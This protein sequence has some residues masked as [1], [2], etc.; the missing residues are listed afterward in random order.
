MQAIQ[1]HPQ[2]NVA[3]AMGDLP[4]GALI[5]VAGATVECKAPIPAMHKLALKS[6]GMGGEVR[7]YGQVIGFASTEIRPGE[8]VHV[9]NCRVGDVEMD[10]GFCRDAVTPDFVPE[11]QRDTFQGY[12]RPG[13][14]AG[15]RNYVGVLTSVN[16]SATVARGIAAVGEALLASGDYPGIDGVVA[17]GHSSGCG[18]Q[19]D[20]EGYLTLR[21]TIVGYARHPNFAAVMLVGLGCET[22][23]ISR[24]M[25]E[26]GLADTGRFRAFTIQESG[27]TRAAI[28]R[29]AAVLREMLPL[30]AACRR[31]PVPVSELAMAVQCGGSDAFSGITANP[32]LGAAGDILVRQGGTVIYSETPEICGAEHLL[33]RRAATPEVAEAL[34]ERIRWWEQY[35]RINGIQLDSNP[36]PGNKAGGLTTILEKSLGAQAKSGSSPMTGVYRYAEPIARHGLAFMDSPGYDPVSVTGQVASGANIICFTTGRGSAFGFK[37]VPSLKLASNSALFQRMRDDMDVDCG[38]VLEGAR[39][40]QDMGR[41]IYQRVLAIAS[42]ERSKSEE[43]GYGDCEFNPW[44]IGATV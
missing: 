2:D 3:V 14:A 33:T 43:L 35:T 9:Q 30:A 6:I 38:P 15:T 21:R 8:H 27:G 11:Q 36:S 24:V 41:E 22:L 32:S 31:E 13:G 4:A 18:M 29:G 39:D 23:Q 37:P 5:T 10:Y 16:C 7:K 25:E 40:V 34:L 20:D 12:R 17:L 44:K 26:G 42:G 1:I 28:E 19:G